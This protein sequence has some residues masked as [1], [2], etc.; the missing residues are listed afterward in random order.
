MERIQKRNHLGT[1]R[2]HRLQSSRKLRRKANAQELENHQRTTTSTPTITQKIPL[3]TI[4]KE[5]REAC[6]NNDCICRHK[7]RHSYIQYLKCMFSVLS[8]YI[9]NAC[10]HSIFST[11]QKARFSLVYFIYFQ[12]SFRILFFLF[13][14]CFLY[15][16]LVF[17]IVSEVIFG[18]KFRHD[19]GSRRVGKFH[20]SFMLFQVFISY[21]SLEFD[22]L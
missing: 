3:R 6:K 12:F 9:T 21:L 7:H 11:F 13:E 20:I 8:H 14:T 1:S 17:F 10:F 2:Q 18:H 5:R 16:N 19:N 4:K 22:C 15:L